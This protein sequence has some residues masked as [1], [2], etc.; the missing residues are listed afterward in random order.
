[1]TISTVQDLYDRFGDELELE[2]DLVGKDNPIFPRDEVSKYH[3]SVVGPF[4]MIRPNRIQII[5]PPEYEHLHQLIKDD[6]HSCIDQLFAHRPC[7][8]IFTDGLTPTNDC[9]LRASSNHTALMRTNLQDV[10]VITPLL[11]YFS[12]P[13]LET[14]LIHG[15]FMEVMGKGVLLT[16]DPAIGKSEL[17]LELISRGHR[18]V[19][20]DV[21]EFTRLANNMLSGKSPA[22]LQDFLEVRGLGIMNVRAM[23]GN[24]AI[25]PAKFLHL[26]LD[27]K[28]QHASDIADHERISGIHSTTPILGIKVSTTTLPV[29]PG[30]NLAILVETAVRQYLLEADGYDAGEDFNQRQQALIERDAGH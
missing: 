12:Q 23:F 1:M 4:N 7:L 22:L 9:I 28:H 11:A 26:I 16:G 30:R 18:L 20:D 10:R 5:G 17:A 15:V 24:S 3:Y 13:K 21:T 14:T 29:A 25:K 6:F 19:A 27:L 8:I 2:W